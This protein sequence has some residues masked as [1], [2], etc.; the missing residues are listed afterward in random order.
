MIISPGRRFIFVH[1]PK[2]GGTSMAAALEARAHKDDI[3]IGDTPKARKRRARVELLKAPGRLWKHSTLADIQG[4]VPFDDMFVFC[5]VRNPWDRLVSYYHWLQGQSFDHPAV[6]L[7][8]RLGFADFLRHPFN[9]GTL[10]RWDYARYVT[11]AAGEERCDLFL[12]LER[13]HEDWGPLV[14]RL[15][16]EPEMGHEN[17][18]ERGDY[19]GYYDD[20][21]AEWVGEV[22]ARDIARFGYAF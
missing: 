16:F 5:L 17:R 14:D 12:R 2:T 1:I 22:C 18:S 6:G 8:Q 11:D 15:G 4:V 7:A 13:L 9:E 20:A 21:L 19:R 10:R 3:L